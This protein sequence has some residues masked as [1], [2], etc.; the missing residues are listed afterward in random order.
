MKW[1]NLF[2]SLAPTDVP[3]LNNVST[4]LWKEHHN[5][6][7]TW[8]N[9]TQINIDV[10]AKISHYRNQRRDSLFLKPMRSSSG[11]TESLNICLMFKNY[12]N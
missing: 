12:P 11:V 9:S 8:E 10:E 6:I 5:L 2:V 1:L 7:S 4:K 3:L